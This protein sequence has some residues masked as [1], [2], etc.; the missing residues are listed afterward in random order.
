[1]SAFSNFASDFNLIVSI[2]WTFCVC[3]V[4]SVV[5]G[6]CYG[7][8]F[9]VINLCMLFSILTFCLFLGCFVFVWGVLC[10]LT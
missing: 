3:C 2:F 7:I 5:L 6:H 1:M 9:L 8:V 10:L 4:L